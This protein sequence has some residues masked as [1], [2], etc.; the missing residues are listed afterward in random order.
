MKKIYTYL[1]EAAVLGWL[2]FNRNPNRTITPGNNI[3]S[4]AD[5]TVVDINDNRIEIFIGLTDVHYQRIPL[6]GTVIHI[7]N[8]GEE[9]NLIELDTSLGIIT[10]ERWAGNIA[11]TVTTDV[12][13]GDSLNKGDTIGR[14][15]LGSH[16][17]ITI[18]PGLIIK[19]AKGQH[20]FAGETIIAE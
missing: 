16:T 7:T 20:V 13:I 18:P 6:D 15:V 11:K 1:A 9:Y 19:V 8:M 10:I 14:I 12:K 5:G 3:V 4:P 17:A 2:F